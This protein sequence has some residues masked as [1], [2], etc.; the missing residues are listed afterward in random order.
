MDKKSKFSQ[1]FK[2]MSE[3]AANFEYQSNWRVAAEYWLITNECAQNT[4][5]KEWSYS[6]HLFCHRMYI[7]DGVW[8]K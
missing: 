3:Q 6:R 8:K 4:D 1:G 2:R 5:N 7:N